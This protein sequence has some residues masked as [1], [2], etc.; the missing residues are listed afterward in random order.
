VLGE[1]VQEL[2]SIAAAV[3]HA[4]EAPGA[5]APELRVEAAWI[6]ADLEDRRRM[7]RQSREQAAT[8]AARLGYLLG[9]DPCAVLEP[10]DPHLMVVD[11]VDANQPECQLVAQALANGPGIREMEG[12][13]FVIH[14][15]IGQSKS[16]LQW[17][18]SFE[19]RMAEGG[20][21]AGA[22]STL[23]WDNRWDLGLQM[24]WNLT[25]F[26][27]QHGTRASYQAQERQAVISYQDLRSKLTS[28]VREAQ[29]LILSSRDQMCIAQE[30]IRAAQ[31]FRELA[32]ERRERAI[33]RSYQERVQSVLA[34]A[35][36][37]TNYLNAVRA[38]D[39]AQLQLMLLLGP[40]ATPCPPPAAIPNPAPTPPRP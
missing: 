10:V 36:A 16:P 8:A 23:D 40:S 32:R 29:T 15:S 37:R 27:R 7:L 31:R 3:Q 2:E 12:L 4:A 25:D 28:G 20:F 38:Y 22:G 18:P 30:E 11:L 5:P 21:G 35:R 34:L 1:L 6:R 14:E 24:R 26:A 33:T 13:L 9:L 17:L 39:K 19:M